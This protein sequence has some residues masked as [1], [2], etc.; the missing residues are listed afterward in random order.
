MVL[1][2]VMDFIIA[3]SGFKLLLIPCE[4][5]LPLWFS[6]ALFFELLLSFAIQ[7][8]NV[9][10]HM[11]VIGWSMWFSEYLFLERSW[12]KDESTLKV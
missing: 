11:Q 8:V 7:R 10:I 4:C 3:H 1:V 9:P 6:F 5:H 2:A 12:A